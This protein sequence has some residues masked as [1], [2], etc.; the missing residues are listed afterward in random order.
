MSKERQ[1]RECQKREKFMF[2]RAKVSFIFPC[3]ESAWSI[4]VN[5][6]LDELLKVCLVF[7]SEQVERKHDRKGR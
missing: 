5:F 6:F 2:I 3:A 7:V 1:K 4:F